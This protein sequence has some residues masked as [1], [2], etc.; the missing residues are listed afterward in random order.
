M[1]VE[2]WI[3]P[4][5]I[6]STANDIA[7]RWGTG[8][9]SWLLRFTS[10]GA[11][12]LINY[13]GASSSTL[14]STGPA[15]AAGSLY[16]VAAYYDGT[17]GCL[18]QNGVVVAG[19]TAMVVPQASTVRPF[20]LFCQSDTDGGDYSTFHFLG[21]MGYCAFY[22]AAVSSTRFLAHYKTGLRNGVIVG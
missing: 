7:C 17:N 16:H 8:G 21:K 2:A 20:S 3:V 22:R 5:S 6:N 4:S 18:V 1:A 9:P 10:A 15:I 13:N 11:L 14:T 19:P 12:T